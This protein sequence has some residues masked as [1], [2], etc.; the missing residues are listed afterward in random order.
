M[1]GRTLGDR[2]IVESRVGGGGMATVYRG[3]DTYLRRQVALKVL[4]NQFAGDAD[5]VA[6]FRREARAA[7]SLSHPNI[8]AVYDVGQQ[9]DDCYY[10]VQEFVDGRTLKERIQ[11]EGPLP[12]EEA[13]RITTQVLRALGQ[14]HASGIIH[15]DVKP[16]N[17]LLTRDGRV[18]VTDF[19]IAHAESGVTMA[20]SGAIVG[21]A[22]YAAPEQVRGQPTDER[23]DIYSTGVMLYEM[24]VGRPPFDGDGPLAVALQHIEQPV[25]DLRQTRPDLPRGVCALV[26]RAMS[27]HPDQRYRT[28]AEFEADVADIAAGRAPAH[29][30]QALEQ[31]DIA[32]GVF[33]AD[34][35][36][37]PMDKG[38][39]PPTPRRRS[40]VARRVAWVAGSVVV[41]GLLIAGGVL[42]AS[43]ALYVPTVPV[44]NVTGKDMNAAQNAL[45]GVGLQPY[46]HTET[47]LTVP[48]NEVVSTDPAA[49]TL[50][51]KGERV[52]VWTSSGPPS[53][54]IPADLSGLT[55]ASAT[56][57]LK[58]MQLQVQVQSTPQFSPTVQAGSVISTVPA[59]G[60]Q[61]P[62]GSTVTLTLSAGPQ[63]SGALPDYVGKDAAA[64][65]TDITTG[66]QWQYTVT[67][68]KSGWPLGTVAA[69]DPAPG[70]P[71]LP[72]ASVAVTV[73]SGCVYALT[74]TFQATA[75][76]AAG[77]GGT[78]VATVPQSGGLSPGSP[79]G[80]ST[81]GSAPAQPSSSASS[82]A[83]S[84]TPASG[85]PGYEEQVLL[86][87]GAGP[88]RSV[89]N[90]VVPP[91]QSFQVNFCWASPQG[92][93]YTW[94]ENGV[95][96]DTQTLDSAKN[97]TGGQ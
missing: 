85:S 60:A 45:A 53:V 37:E 74:R 59:A 39:V 62:A 69:T 40:V 14:A 9:D 71:L 52:N 94:M 48:V 46:I 13:L 21:T 23:G 76:P 80:F 96:R 28:T 4:R 12:P 65:E 49:G 95:T 77:G 3:M 51:R 88:S 61:V 91:G 32:A 18:K 89:F 22:H 25:P 44:P 26:R 2:Y 43:R 82:S 36:Q 41:V 11:Q 34:T 42:A 68:Q 8:V 7:A 27:K 29:A 70:T 93:T 50:L 84:S 10:I 19:G 33:P 54:Q 72:G 6:R 30:M 75:A 92:A 58:G 66:H 38:D 24:L 17:V 1:I 35:A 57:E 86:Q 55:Q 78:G 67:Q 87:D 79:P 63:E 81:T 73:S 16:Q 5:F 56:A 97:A 15:R 20:H 47:T 90:Q 83:A 64:V 31:A